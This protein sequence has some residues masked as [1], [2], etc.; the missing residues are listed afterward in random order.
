MPRVQERQAASQE[1]F[2][3]WSL[4][5]FWCF[6]SGVS[7]YT[8]HAIRLMQLH[9]YLFHSTGESDVEVCRRALQEASLVF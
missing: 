8:L 5:F 4:V 7:S 9:S 1:S 6:S 3:F 2:R